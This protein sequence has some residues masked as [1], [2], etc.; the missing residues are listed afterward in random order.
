MGTGSAS[1]P[2]FAD[3][4]SVDA[5]DAWLRLVLT[6]AHAE[7]APPLLASGMAAVALEGVD[8]T[9]V[10]LETSRTGARRCVSV[11]W[12]VQD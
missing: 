7:A 8:A 9:S 6:R 5:C 3:L 10:V 1:H 2:G 4:S 12:R 11:E